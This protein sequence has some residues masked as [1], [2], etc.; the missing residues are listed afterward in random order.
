LHIENNFHRKDRGDPE[1]AGLVAIATF[2]T[3]VNPPLVSVSMT[4]VRE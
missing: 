2:S 3:I 1:S 4:Y